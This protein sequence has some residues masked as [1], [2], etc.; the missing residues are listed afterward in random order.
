MNPSS[1]A[2]LWLA[3]LLFGLTLAAN[4]ATAP[5][6]LTADAIK[7]AG[8]V[9]AALH[10]ARAAHSVP[11]LGV[12]L[13]PLPLI[14]LSGAIATAEAKVAGA[15]AK[16]VLEQQ[17]MA[18]A[19]ALYQ[20]HDTSLADYQKA[21]EDLAANQA[22]LAVERTKRAALLAE[23]EASWGAATAAALRENADPLPQLA[24]GTEM[25][26][27][28]SLPPGTMLAAPPQQAVAMAAGVRCNLRLVGLVPRML[29]GYPGQSLLYVAAMQPA[30]PIGTTISASLPTGPEGDGV[31]VPWSA[32]S[33]QNGRA[34][35]FRVGAGNRVEPV[36]IATDTPI[37]DGYFVSAVLSPGDH[38]I[39]SGADLLLGVAQ[40]PP[41]AAPKK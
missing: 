23:S 4:A 30:M 32:V 22:L 5:T 10:A 14:R 18:Q 21:Q 34:L 27:G 7:R 15:K 39:V 24:A 28:L 8:I 33:W 40:D 37:A 11:A 9:V 1:P 6:V 38:V 29:G 41:I 35:V 12:V 19:S 36:P 31:L 20:R 16:V 25:L 26:V 17:Q 3:P 13:D 2:L